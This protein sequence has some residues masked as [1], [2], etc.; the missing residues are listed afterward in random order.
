MRIS[1]WSSDVCSSDLIT[2]LSASV[3]SVTGNV[4][5]TFP[6]TTI[7]RTWVRLSCVSGV[8]SGNTGKSFVLVS[9]PNVKQAN[10]T[11]NTSSTALADA[12]IKAWNA[13]NGLAQTSPIVTT[14]PTGTQTNT[15][16]KDRKS[17]RLNS[18]H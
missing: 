2:I 4:L 15:A 8:L 14:P 10:N 3:T 1:D 12:A 9:S 6:V 11:I 18:S 5:V 13:A 17:T 7:D 16:S